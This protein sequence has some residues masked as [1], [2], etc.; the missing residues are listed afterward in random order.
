MDNKNFII[1]N[2]L[3]HRM[4]SRQYFGC[5]IPYIIAVHILH[6]Y[7]DQIKALRKIVF[8][9]PEATRTIL[10]ILAMKEYMQTCRLFSL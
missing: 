7:T 9:L 1:S 3:S 10:L 5:E 8:P 2:N 6:V 4:A